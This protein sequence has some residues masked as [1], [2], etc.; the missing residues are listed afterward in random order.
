MSGRAASCDG[1][2]R[3]KGCEWRKSRN[4]CT[5]HS[6]L[7]S[8]LERRQRQVSDTSS[9]ST[10]QAGCALS[11]SSSPPS[12]FGFSVIRWMVQRNENGLPSR[13]PL[14][15]LVVAARR[16]SHTNWL[17]RN[18]LLSL[19]SVALI[20]ILTEREV[21]RSAPTVGHCRRNRARRP[22]Q[23]RTDGRSARPERVFLGHFRFERRDRLLLSLAALVRA[24]NSGK[25]N[26]WR[27][28]ERTTNKLSL[29][30]TFL[31][32]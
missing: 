9:C 1:Q 11:F 17:V 4:I 19:K 10:R 27:R 25:S 13:A 32:L 23:R 29:S 26:C 24:A 3:S 21:T 22:R 30:H 16:S 18:L 15:A 8:H 28:E 5:L 31:P 6:A 20:N 12:L 2:C 7:G 14:S